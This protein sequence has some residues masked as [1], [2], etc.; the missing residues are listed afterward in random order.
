MEKVR[1]DLCPICRRHAHVVGR[2]GSCGPEFCFQ[3]DG[4]RILLLGVYLQ[5]FSWEEMF[6]MGEELRQ[7]PLPITLLEVDLEFAWKVEVWNTLRQGGEL[8]DEDTVWVHEYLEDEPVTPI[9]PD[10][11]ETI[12]ERLDT[13]LH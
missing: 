3:R 11:V 8:S 2:T 12:T 5:H 9:P 10:F 1:I 7:L 4:F 13:S 6:A